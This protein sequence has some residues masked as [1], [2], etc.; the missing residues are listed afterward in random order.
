MV[1]EGFVKTNWQNG[2]R[3]RGNEVLVQCG[4][5]GREMDAHVIVWDVLLRVC[6]IHI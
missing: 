1:F 4:V 6:C 5:D 3:K 2:A